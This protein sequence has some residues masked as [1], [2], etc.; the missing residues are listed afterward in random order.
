MVGMTTR[1]AI[2][3]FGRM[4]RLVVRALRHHP[5]L[6]LVHVN[7]PK[8][9]VECAA[10]LLQFDTV[11][12]RYEG[13]AAAVDG[14]L[15]VD[16]RRIGFSEE[17][18]PGAVPWKDAGVDLVLECSGRFRTME[19]LEPYFDHGIRK[20]VVAAPVK[21]ERAL[22]IVM[23]CNDHLYDPDRHDV[24]TAASCTTNCIAPV[25]KVLHEQV[26]IDQGVIT[27]I[28]DVTNTQ[29]VVDA[30]HA[31]LRRA[32][33]ALNALIPTSTG[34]ATA[35]TMI[36]PELKGRLNGLAVRVPLL[37][38]SL[39]DCV[40][41][42]AR[43][44]TAEELNGLFA[45]AAG[46]DLEGILGCESRP[47]VSTDYVNDTRSGIVD[48]PSTMVVDGNLVKVLVWYDNEYGYVHRMAELAAKVAHSLEPAGRYSA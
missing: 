8:G 13:V 38:A 1:I 42:L 29:V 47:L 32:R 17:T 4:G 40:F 28:H 45:R 21:D 6:E 15:E 25:V 3:G 44:S 39:T 24:V 37:N 46:D 48:A 27:T 12:G 30:P 22:N 18:E 14:M 7:E 31:D 26:G 35:I 33:S 19:L 10:H 2:N 11:H 34:S 9:G 23:G 36:Y 5:E 41:T 16:G 43:E 20:V